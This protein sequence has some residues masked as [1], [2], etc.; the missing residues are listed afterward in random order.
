[1]VSEGRY[2][3]RVVRPSFMTSRVSRKPG[4]A[5]APTI[6]SV[7][8]ILRPKEARARLRLLAVFSK[9][10]VS[11]LLQDPEANKAALSAQPKFVRPVNPDSTATC[12]ASS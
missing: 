8:A 9:L 5:S 4:V 1:M 3:P 6:A 12:N 10:G 2:A 7:R 11:L